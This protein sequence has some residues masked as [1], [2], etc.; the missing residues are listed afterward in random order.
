MVD[1]DCPLHYL[2]VCRCD[3]CK[4]AEFL[5]GGGLVSAGEMVREAAQAIQ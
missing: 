2:A 3:G 1:L 5:S 4:S